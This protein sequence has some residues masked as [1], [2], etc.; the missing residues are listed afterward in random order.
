MKDVPVIAVATLEGDKLRARMMHYAYDENFNIYLSTLK[1]EPKIGQ[2]TNH[3]AISLLAHHAGANINE[4]MEV[5]ISGEALFIQ[6]QKEREQ[7]FE[8]MAKRSPVVKNLT[9]TG[10]SGILECIKV[11]PDTVKF[12]IFKEVVQGI[13]PTVIEFH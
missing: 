6:G 1:G 3:S 7:A 13:P 8:R 11:V 5:E 12:R 9:E 10:N 4:S 2:M